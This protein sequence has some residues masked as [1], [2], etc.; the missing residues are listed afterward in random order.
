MRLSLL[1][2][3]LGYAGAQRQL[4]ALAKGLDRQQFQVTVFCFYGGPLQAELEAAGVTVRCLEKKNRWDMLGFLWRVVKAL[5]A[6]RPDVLYSFLAESNL[7]ACL[8]KPLLPGTRVVLGVR[9]SETDAAL[10]GWLGRFVFALGRVVA[11]GADLVI[12]NSQSGARYYAEQGYPRLTVVPNG[13]DTGRF[14]PD[15][16]ARARVRAELGVGEGETLFGIV[17]RLSPMKD[18]ATFLQAAAT[19]GP[20]ARFLCVGGGSGPHG[21]AMH[22][23][24]SQL[25]LEPRL[26][27]SP[28]RGDMPEVFNALDALVSS[29]AFGEGFSNVVGEAMACGTPCIVTDVG[30]S[31]W[32]VAESGVTVPPRQPE[33]LAT[34]MRSFMAEDPQHRAAR[35]LQARA[36]MEKNF[37][38]PRMVERTAALLI[39]EAGPQGVEDWSAAT[40]SVPAAPDDGGTPSLL[41]V[42]AQ[43]YQRTG[44]TGSFSTAPGM[45]PS[46]LPAG[47]QTRETSR[48]RLL[49]IITALGTG[50]AEMMLAQLITHLDH[51]RFEPAVIS[52]TDGGKHMDSLRQ[53]GIP[54]HSLGMTGGRPSLGSLLR[55]RSLARSFRPDLL[56]GWMYHGNLAASLA[57]WIGWHVPVLWN[58]RQSLY[59]LALEK[60]GSALVIKALAWLGFNPRQVLYNSSISARQHE[61]IGY[62]KSKTLLVPNGFNTDTFKPDAAARASVLQELDLPDNALLLG[63]FGRHSDMKDY[64]SF[65]KAMEHLQATHPNVHAII[66]GTG[67]ETLA[68]VPASVH[69]LGERHDLPRLTAALDIGCSSSAF[70]E[71][72]PNVVAEAMSCAVPCVVT[73][74]GDSTW[75]LGNSGKSA[76]ARDPEA[77]AGAISALVALPSAERRALGQAGRQRILT[78]FSLPAVVHKFET[79]FTNSALGTSH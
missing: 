72:F 7:L 67:T 35:E 18:H 2:R 73:D 70:G 68:A 28:P 37:T 19:L 78:D 1:I 25:G 47:S 79:L 39:A 61:A 69:V 20:G 42:G 57:S 17:G 65:L 30:D 6:V 77:F 21:E 51:T 13:I 63:R 9:D 44:N 71:G 45:Q 32:L 33:A 53:A 10:Y 12:A 49:F 31:A 43:G 22:A 75:L 29:S 50:G 56:I 26:T 40:A 15:E 16:Q 55:L 46:L 66:A 27:W 41:G 14:Q 54:V 5:R 76:P 58:V 38:V 4:V 74:V 48:L 24:A 8:M 59:C 60:R 36:R 52:L 64:P 3:D 23:L 11:R 34:V 62:P